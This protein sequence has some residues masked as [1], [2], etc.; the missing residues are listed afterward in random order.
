MVF[1][2]QVTTVTMAFDLHEG[3]IYN[4][5]SLQNHCIIKL[6]FSARRRY[7]SFESD[8]SF[9]VISSISQKNCT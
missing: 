1:M 4:E 7:F 3:K 2:L 8:S 6:S 9:S 5:I